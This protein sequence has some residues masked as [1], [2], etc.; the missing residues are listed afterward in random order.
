MAD[1]KR[2]FKLWVSALTDD[3]VQRLPPADRWAW[4]ALGAYTKEQGTAGR[5]I[6]SESNAALAAAIGVPLVDLIST[7]QRL[8]HVRVQPLHEGPEKRHG[9]FTV[10]WNNWIKYQE[11]TT[12]A[13]RQ[14]TSRSKRRGEEKRRESPPTP[15]NQ[16]RF[17]S[18]KLKPPEGAAAPTTVQAVLARIN[19][20]FGEAEVV[21]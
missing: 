20:K 14:R 18:P 8:P 13:E 4:A 16:D 6:V 15:P 17:F 19:S 5:V 3:H 9:T 12:R 21:G 11:D 2:W 7:L 1:Q 10:T